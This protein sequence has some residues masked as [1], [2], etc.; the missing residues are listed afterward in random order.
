MGACGFAAGIER[1]L[2]A[3]AS[4]PSAQPPSRQGIYLATATPTLAS[5]SFRFAQQLRAAGVVAAL[6][7]DGRSLKAQLREADKAGCRLVAILGEQEL[8]R[9][10]ITVKDLEQGGLQES[11]AFEVF[12][13][14]I[15]KRLKPPVCH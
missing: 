11:I 12:A 5:E 2:L 13:E 4:A 6:D 15:A 9:R 10:E 1:V 8:K 14:E 7:Y 3:A